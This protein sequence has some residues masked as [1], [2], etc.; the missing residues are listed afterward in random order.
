MQESSIRHQ[1]ELS[2][3]PTKP[4]IPLGGT[5]NAPAKRERTARNGN[6]KAKSHRI[7]VRIS[8]QLHQALTALSRDLG[9]DLSHVIRNLLEVSL[10]AEVA[11][12]VPRKPVMW[13]EEIEPLVHHYRAVVDEDIRKV[14]K[15][16]FGH[17]LAVSVVCKEKFARTP[18]MLEGHQSLLGLQHLFGFGENV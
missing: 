15:R 13:P 16:L 9:C 5:R 4:N 11:P 6:P 18:G 8:D 7:N 1:E 10:C 3:I 2:G 12:N 17:L 14:R